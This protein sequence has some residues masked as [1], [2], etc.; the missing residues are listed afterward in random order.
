MNVTMDILIGSGALGEV[1]V[2]EWWWL[3]GLWY[4]FVEQL[5]CCG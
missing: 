2:D 5:M 4:V 1:S 3:G